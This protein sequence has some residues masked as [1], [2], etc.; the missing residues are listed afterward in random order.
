M[1]LFILISY[2]TFSKMPKYNKNM[3]LVAE[4]YQ[5]LELQSICISCILLVLA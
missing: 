1:T 3:R 5:C 4:K 2:D